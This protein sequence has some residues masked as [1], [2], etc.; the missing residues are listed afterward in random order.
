MGTWGIILL[1]VLHQMIGFATK[2]SHTKNYLASSRNHN[3]NERNEKTE[4][5]QV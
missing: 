5:E 2:S 4:K 3:D 1:P